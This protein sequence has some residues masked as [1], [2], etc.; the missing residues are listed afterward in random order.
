MDGIDIALSPTDIEGE[1]SFAQSSAEGI[2]RIANTCALLKSLCGSRR[3]I[4]A[5]Q[6]RSVLELIDGELEFLDDGLQRV[7]S[8]YDR[9]NPLPAPSTEGGHCPTDKKMQLVH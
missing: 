8:F 7:V 3:T 6:L 4:N 1:A 5:E 9:L 2:H